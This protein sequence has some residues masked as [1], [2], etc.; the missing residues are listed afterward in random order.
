MLNILIPMAGRGSRFA[1]AGFKLPKPMIPVGEQPMIEWVVDNLRT[2]I[3]HRFIFLCLT[4]HLE[5]LGM[6]P[7]LKRI[8]PG[9]E[10]VNIDSVTA[11]AACTC[12][13]AKPWIDNDE[14]LV[15]ANSDQFVDA[16]FQS[17]VDSLMQPGVDGSIMTMTAD[18]PKWSYVRYDERGRIVE[19]VEKQVVSHDA[20]VGIYGFRRGAE[21]VAAAEAMIAQDLRVNGEFY[22]AP[23]YNQMIA[24]NARLTTW[25]VGSEANGMYGLGTPA[26]LEQFL[27]S[28]VFRRETARRSQPSRRA[29]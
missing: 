10:I 8:A 14:P 15:I 29:G 21:F 7:L 12:L 24:R 25:G 5:H 4:E 27:R 1:K 9:C 6:R 16:D 13:L 3:P 22:V 17:F 28:E 20:T 2:N 18:D 11:G 26:D 23:A 19:V